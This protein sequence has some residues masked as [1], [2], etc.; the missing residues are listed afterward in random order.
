MLK[1]PDINQQLYAWAVM[2]A[3]DRMANAYIA[4]FDPEAEEDD[5]SE[6]EATLN[7]AVRDYVLLR[8]GGS[9]V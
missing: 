1:M 9:I 7:E 4:T 2:T 8:Q 6:L 5:F 3:A